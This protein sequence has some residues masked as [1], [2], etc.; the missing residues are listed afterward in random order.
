MDNILTF[1]KKQ[2]Q[3]D[4]RGPTADKEALPAGVRQRILAE[5]VR[6]QTPAQSTSGK[7]GK[8][9]KQEAVTVT[10]P[11][12]QEEKQQVQHMN[13]R[14]AEAY[15]SLAS[16]AILVH[17]DSPGQAGPA[18]GPYKMEIHYREGKA[19]HTAGKYIDKL[20]SLRK[21]THNAIELRCDAL[22]HVI[23]LSGISQIKNGKHISGVRLVA[24]D[25]DNIEP[26]FHE[27]EFSPEAVAARLLGSLAATY[28][29]LNREYNIA[30]LN[31]SD[32]VLESNNP[33]FPNVPLIK[34]L[35]RPDI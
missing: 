1:P 17:R 28:N 16:D 31:I 23:Y 24:Y 20:R 30:G 3:P 29:K 2:Q 9:N 25:F 6:Q 27:V 22:G 10:R 21:L 7:G 5:H 4:K 8:R 15:H 18:L 13:K 12:T 11:F 35:G 14:V 19:I 32:I 33:G 34:A 26:T